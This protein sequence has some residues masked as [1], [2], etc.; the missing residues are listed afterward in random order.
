MSSSYNLLY[1]ALSYLVAAA[2]SY[3]A[4]ALAKQLITPKQKDWRPMLLSAGALTLGTGIWAMHFVGMLAFNMNMQ[5]SYDPSLTIWS[6]LVAIA[7]AFCMLSLICRPQLT[8]IQIFGGAGLIGSGI[9]SMH[10]IGMKAMVTDAVMLYRPGIFILSIVIAVTASAAALWICF[11]LARHHGRFRHYLDGLASLVMATAICGMHY[12]GMAAAVFIP[13]MGSHKAAS[14]INSNG[15]TLGVSLIGLVLCFVLPVTIYYTINADEKE[16]AAESAS[17]F[18]TKLLSLAVAGT[19]GV[20]IW[21]CGYSVYS[22]H[23]ITASAFRA[24]QEHR[25]SRSLDAIALV[26]GLFAGLLSSTWY[27]ALR[28]IRV[29][30]RELRENRSLLRTVIDNMPLAMFVKDATNSCR[31]MYLNRKAQKM[32]EFPQDVVGRLDN[33]LFPPKEAAFFSALDQR[34]MA[35]GKLVDIEAAPIMTPKG[36]CTVHAIEV[37]VYDPDGRPHIL[38]GMA[39]DVTER[40]RVSED[41]RLAKERAEK[42]DHA[43][44]EFLANMSHELRTPLNSILGTIRLLQESGLDFGQKDLAETVAMS[45]A[46]LLEIVEDILDLSKIEAGAVQLEQI[47][48]DPTYLLMSVGDRLR[49]LAAEKNLALTIDNMTETPYVIGDPTRFGRILTNLISNAIKYTD[50]GNVRVVVQCRPSDQ[51]HIL[52]RCEVIDTGIGIPPEKHARIFEK[53]TQADSSTT[54]KYGGTGL[55]LAITKQLIELM[56]GEIGVKSEIGQGSNFWFE[57]GFLTTAELYRE[58]GPVCALP[59]RS[60]IRPQDARV[61][62][63]E[64]HPMN[65]VLI[66]R[67][68]CRFGVEHIRIVGDGAEAVSVYAAEPWDMI[69][70][71]CHMPLKNGYDATREIRALAKEHNRQ[72]VPIVA[73]TAN[74]MIGDR[75]KCLRYG[76]D[77]YISKPIVIEVLARL[78]RQWIDLEGVAVGPREA[79]AGQARCFDLGQM[80]S[81]TDGDKAM[82]KDLVKLFVDQSEVNIAALAGNQADGVCSE[83][84]EAAHM[85]KGGAASIGAEEL[86]RLCEAAQA[87]ERADAQAR[88]ESFRKIDS[89][90]A[91]VKYAL[92]GEGLLG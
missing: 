15:I 64:D 47:G 59:R 19:F 18:P 20:L 51:D 35:E 40:M 73:M 56:G 36:E 38:L 91:N 39:E 90:Y 67:L 55:G 33:E 13:K 75:E 65:Q 76:M 37:P 45:S 48:F 34:V 81:F 32:F 74:A 62:I 42:S 24:A 50:R 12:T 57:I 60:A 80:R 53:F 28:S 2:A 89:A 3:L 86:R 31:W 1:V 78:M 26:A 54:R 68:M 87:M 88:S 14:G 10:Y 72:H 77:D 6:L 61:L 92:R 27:L 63:A 17:P 16:N 85:L 41:L 9:S 71:D 5:V 23:L 22:S 79:Q 58:S 30:R 25:I 7:S 11:T 84:V 46:N 29:W 49:P 4:L 52:Y 82:E 66:R 8:P 44:S 83:W 70:M 43:K 69:L 21:V